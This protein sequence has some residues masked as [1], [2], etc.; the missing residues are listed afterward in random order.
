MRQT[1][2]KWTAHNLPRPRVKKGVYR[3]AIDA[4]VREFHL[5]IL[6]GNAGRRAA[7]ANRRAD[8]GKA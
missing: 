5:A 2:V 7:A 6:A 4:W 8:H 1:K 3:A